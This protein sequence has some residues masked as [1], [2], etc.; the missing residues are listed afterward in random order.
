MINNERLF[1]R[2][3][4]FGDLSQLIYIVKIH[5]DSVNIWYIFEINTGQHMLIMHCRL[6]LILVEFVL[7]SIGMKRKHVIKENLLMGKKLNIPRLNASSSSEGKYLSQ[8][9][10]Q[11]PGAPSITRW[12][13]SR[14]FR[15]IYLFTLNSFHD[16]SESQEISL[17]KYTHVSNL[18]V[19]ILT[20]LYWK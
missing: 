14:H 7:N 15:L 18:E 2:T 17:Q 4:A 8:G 19:E 1:I 11:F 16:I 12:R 10:A 13:K 5:L 9:G 3:K 6:V 20:N